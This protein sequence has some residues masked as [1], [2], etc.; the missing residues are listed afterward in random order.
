MRP[1]WGYSQK[2]GSAPRAAGVTSI[3]IC[4]RTEAWST[5]SG[6]PVSWAAAGVPVSGSSDASRN[7]MVMMGTNLLRLVETANDLDMQTPSILDEPNQRSGKHTSWND[8]LR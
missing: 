6:R 7:S 5:L 8:P 2:N 4:N 1:P 3:T